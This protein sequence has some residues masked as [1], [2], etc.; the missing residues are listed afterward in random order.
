MD[1]AVEAKWHTGIFFAPLREVLEHP[2]VS[3]L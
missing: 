2:A 1:L 3:G